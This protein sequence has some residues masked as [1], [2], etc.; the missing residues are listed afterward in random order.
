MNAF[1]D[2]AVV[3]LILTLFALCLGLVELCD[4]I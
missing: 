3:A 1:V 2:A 4:R